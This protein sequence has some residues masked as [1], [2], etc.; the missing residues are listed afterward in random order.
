MINTHRIMIVLS[1]LLL[2]GLACARSGIPTAL[3]TTRPAAATSA[4]SPVNPG[5]PTPA[6]LAMLPGVNPGLSK[7]VLS[8]GGLQRDYLLYVPASADLGK[9]QALVFALHGGTGNA[10][11]FMQTSGLNAV[12]DQRGF[13]VIYPNGSGRLGIDKLLTWNAGTCCGYAQQENI[14]DVGFVRSLLASLRSQVSIDPRRIYATGFSNGAILAQRLACQAAD[15][16]AAVAPV[17]GTLNFSPCAPSQP[18]SL[19]EFHGTAD[20]NILYTGGYGPDSIARVNFSSVAD[21]LK[22]WSGFDGCDA[23]ARSTPLDSIQL[24]TW[25]GCA[26]GVSVQLYSIVGGKHAWPVSPLAAA[27]VM[28]DFFAAHPKP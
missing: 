3:P 12:A 6:P 2:A 21:T 27:Q 9:P 28:W 8:Y 20:P 24:D 1:S 22:F 4:P 11:N 7:H 26:G 5:T 23:P 16:F 10:N 17:S 13:L 19:I 14:D 25:S 15:I 18:I